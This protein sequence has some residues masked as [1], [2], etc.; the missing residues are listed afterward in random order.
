MTYGH[1]N[2]PDFIVHTPC[3]DREAVIEMVFPKG[4]LLARD[5]TIPLRVRYRMTGLM[6]KQIKIISVNAI[7]SALNE[8]LRY[9]YDAIAQELTQKLNMNG[10]L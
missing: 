6:G 7:P 2:V 3:S 4:Q 1:P 5:V 9:D 8:I 10:A